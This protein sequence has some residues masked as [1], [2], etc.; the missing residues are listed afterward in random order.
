MTG[1]P[2]HTSIQNDQS[3][4]VVGNAIGCNG[5]LPADDGGNAG[6][7]PAVGGTSEE[8]RTWRF[9]FHGTGGEYFK[10]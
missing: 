8:P 6:N 3:G 10:I 2:E 7:M 9:S 1:L 5:T 4:L